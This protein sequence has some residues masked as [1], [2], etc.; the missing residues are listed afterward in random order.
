V[1]LG[2]RRLRALHR[3][4]WCDTAEM[5][6][7]DVSA[8]VSLYNKA[9]DLH[10]MG[11]MARYCALAAAQALDAPDCL[12]VAKLQLHVTASSFVRAEAAATDDAQRAGL[13]RA[14]V[15]SWS[16]GV[17]SLQRRKADG[18]LSAGACR[19][20]EEAFELQTTAHMQRV[21]RDVVDD[22]AACMAP[23]IGYATLLKA[24]EQS[25]LFVNRFVGGKLALT[26]AQLRAAFTLAADAADVMSQTRIH[27]ELAMSNEGMFVK[28]LR[29]VVRQAEL[30]MPHNVLGI[31]RL[32][33]SLHRLERSG[34]L[35]RRGIE[36]AM[37]AYN[38]VCADAESA[39][40]TASAA[41]GLRS[42]A[43]ASCS[44]RE[45]HPK[46]FKA[47]GACRT[48]AYCCKEHQK[49][50]WPAHKAACKAARKAAAERAG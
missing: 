7:P 36:Q 15:E 44:A 20:A 23:L 25:L 13:Y 24:A 19:P 17:T 42:C 29:L 50:H 12:I 39:A 27:E 38:R 40:A 14:A 26:S 21:C 49:E 35:Q 22:A 28:N 5:A 43:L 3:R 9:V 37:Q 2:L 4:T 45:A 8:V 41:P 33:E 16:A 48:P 32:V 6:A 34:V 47:C 11:H 10:T 18:T 30:L 46:L 31:T 1:P